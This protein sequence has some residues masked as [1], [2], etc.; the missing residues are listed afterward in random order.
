MTLY[1]GQAYPSMSGPACILVA[2]A[3]DS[4]SQADVAV[5]THQQGCYWV[6][7][8]A[9]FEQKVKVPLDAPTPVFSVPLGRFQHFKGH[10]YDV[11][12]RARDP[13]TLAPL[14]VYRSPED[15]ATWVRREAMW[16]EEVTWPDGLRGPR[17][18]PV[19]G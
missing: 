2:F 17:F 18:R 5:Y 13:E 19:G 12:C 10:L 6:L 16:S 15:G 1:V 4:E 3:K 9:D 14:L 7:P 8:A 11:V